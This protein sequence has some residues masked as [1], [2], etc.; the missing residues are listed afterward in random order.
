MTVSSKPSRRI[1]TSPQVTRWRAEQARRAARTGADPR[2][3]RRY[4][5][6]AD[7]HAIIAETLA[8]ARAERTAGET[9]DE[10]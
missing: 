8:A 5:W 6:P 7:R 4:G 9:R 2:R 1:D 10:R 3:A